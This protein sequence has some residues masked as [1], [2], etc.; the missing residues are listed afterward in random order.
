MSFNLGNL[1][2]QGVTDVQHAFNGATTPAPQQ[3]QAVAT[4]PSPGQPRP[5]IMHDI[6]NAISH[7]GAAPHPVQINS[8]QVI[9]KIQNAKYGV[10]AQGNNRNIATQQ[11]NNAQR[12]AQPSVARGLGNVGNSFNNAVGNFGM[13]AVVK[14]FITQLNRRYSRYDRPASSHAMGTRRGSRPSSSLWPAKLQAGT[15]R[16]S[17]RLI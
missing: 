8:P 14:P 12:Q 5:S 15:W 16:R 1:L 7:I 6:G 13:N 2:R 3:R 9:Q 17:E 10:L 4:L 11:L